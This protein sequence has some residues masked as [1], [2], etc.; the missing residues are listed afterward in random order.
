MC[1]VDVIMKLFVF[2]DNFDVDVLA[3]VHALER[4]DQRNITIGEIQLMMRKSFHIFDEEEGSNFEVMI[5]SKS[6]DISLIFFPIRFE[7]EKFRL[8]L[9]TVINDG[10]AYVTQFRENVTH[11]YDI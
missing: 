1:I 6:D 7:G 8:I 3:T 4:M 11:V 10:E 9:K 5:R 2:S